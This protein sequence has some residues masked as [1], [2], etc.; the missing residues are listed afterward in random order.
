MAILKTNGEGMSLEIIWFTKLLNLID[1]ETEIQ[2]IQTSNLLH[3]FKIVIKQY[4]C[5]FFL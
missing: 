4:I 1:E 5:Y 3:L 2:R